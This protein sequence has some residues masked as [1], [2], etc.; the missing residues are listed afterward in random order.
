MNV[1]GQWFYRPEE[2]EKRGGGH[3]QSRDLR[4]LFYSFHRDEVPA[5]SVMHKCVVHFIPLNKQIPR[6][7]EHPGFIV[8]KVYCTERRRLFKLTDKDY[9]DNKQEEIDLLVQ[10][11]MSRLGDLPDI[12][13]DEGDV[14]HEEQLTNKRLLRKSNMT[15]LDVSKEEGVFKSAQSLKAETPGSCPSNASEYCAILFQFNV[16]TG[17]TQRD[18]WLEKLL[19]VIHVVC[20]SA[21][22]QADGKEKNSDQRSPDTSGSAKLGNAPEDKSKDV[23]SFCWPDGVVP[24][25]VSLENATHEFFPSDYQKYNQKM[26]QLSYNLK[27][28][29]LLSQRLLNG[30]LEP[31]QI[32]NMTPNELKEGLTAEEIESRQPEESQHLQMTDARCK[33]CSMKEVGLR[34]IIQ[35]G[36]GDRY[37]LECTNCGNTWYAS[38]DQAATLTIGGPS[39]PNSVGTAPL[40]TAKFE[41]VEK[42][43]TSPH[44][45]EKPVA[46]V[47]KKTTEASVPVLDNQRSFNKAKTDTNAGAT[48]SG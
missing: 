37:Q 16:L 47:L 1:M 48:R 39:A 36:T 10:K 13:H 32:L 18:K 11:T 12:E 35:A 24:S 26:R 27:P 22:G 7:K 3:W 28:N 15:P 6:R 38:R 20:T 14:D 30:E 19:Q 5:E 17:D 31:L 42:A 8:Q 45:T 34:D 29:A 40:A 23:A 21:D 33:R 25:V 44:K 9:E 2:A 46:D 43:L 41:D 4:E